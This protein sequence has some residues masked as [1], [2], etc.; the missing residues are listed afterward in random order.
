MARRLR[1]AISISLAAFLVLL[2]PGLE[3]PRIFAQVVGLA[4]AAGVRPIGVLPVA[5]PSALQIGAAPSLISAAP[6][7][8]VPSAFA[9]APS[10]AALTPAAHAAS[11]PD[12]AQAIAPHLEALAKPDATAS[13]AAAAGRGIEDVMTGAR[14]A[15][16]GDV[17]ISEGVEGAGALT[18]APAAAAP[19]ESDKP[20]VPAAAAPAEGKTV[21]SAQSYRAHRFLLKTIAALTGAAYSLP[22]AGP[23]LTQKLIASAAD[24]SAVFSDYD[25]TLAAYNQVLPEDMVSAVQAVKAAGK[26]FVVISDRG[27]EPRA[28][29]LTVFESLA[30][31][32][33][34]TR[35]GMYVAANSGGRVYRYDE[36]GEPVR[37]FEAPPLDEAAKAKVAEAAEATKAR[38]S[39][40]GAEQHVPSATNNNPSESWGTYGYAMMLKVGS[41]NEHVKGAAAILQEEL[42][43]RGLDVEVNPRFAKDPANPPYI[44]FSIVT[45]QTSAE[46]IA[47]AL[48]LEAKDVL[49][50]GDSMYTP[51]EA[52]KESFLTRLGAAL[53]GRALP[54]TGNR[55]DRNMEKAVPGA[56]TFSVGTTGDASAS[57]LWVLA[58][59]GPSVTR[60]VLMSVASKKKGEGGRS[61][62]S[63]VVAPVAVVAG[64]AAAYYFMIHGISNVVAGWEQTIQNDAHEFIKDGGAFFGGVLGL[65][66]LK[67]KIPASWKENAKKA[68][69][70][71]GAIA[72]IT[73]AAFGYH[74][75]LSAFGEVFKA[76]ADQ[77]NPSSVEPLAGLTLGALGAAGLGAMGG[78]QRLT[79]PRD[80][81]GDAYKKAVAIA[82]ER[83]IAEDQVQFS[84]AVAELPALH[85][86]RWNFWFSIPGKDGGRAAIFV[87][88][89]GAA[90]ALDLRTSVYE[91]MPE[92][93]TT[94]KAVAPFYFWIAL[95]GLDAEDAVAAA[96]RAQ[97]G[98]SERVLVALDHRV[99]PVSGD[100]DI[101]YR[102]SDQNGAVVSVNARTSETRVE[103]AVP[104]KD[105][106]RASISKKSP[107][108]GFST[109][110]YDAALAAAREHAVAIGYKPDNLR[111]TGAKLSPRE[112][113]EDWTF[114]FV[115]PRENILKDARAFELKVRRTMVAETQLDAYDL[116]DFGRSPLFVGF[117]AA[118]LPEF[119]KVSPMDIVAKTGDKAR[120]LELRGRWTG[121][122]GEPELWYVVRGEKGRELASYNANTGQLDETDRWAGWK[123]AAFTAGLMA[124][125]A[126]LYALLFWAFTHAPA[127]PNP[128][129]LPE[130]WQGGYPSGD[131][132]ALFGGTLGLAAGTLRGA[133][134]AKVADSEIEGAAKSVVAYKG[135]VWSSTEYNMGYYTTLESL[136]TRGATKAQLERFRK[137]CDEAPVIGGRF[138]P[139]SGD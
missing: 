35:S 44:N 53:S 39:E 97:P 102:V 111:V 104:G 57:N 130:G 7:L 51:T 119:V 19:S 34:E 72:L 41:S 76:G 124:A 117:S 136:K 32:P 113:G 107:V 28:H 122:D 131:I 15:G 49:V 126:G 95:R 82:A 59:K 56:L 40:F 20:A 21:S 67:A 125:T 22:V 77:F 83:G 52:K 108:D 10:A 11:V 4:P 98:M 92:Q 74:A 42:K 96:R 18:L 134:K 100:A 71:V 58:G 25:D 138:N 63:D 81:Y 33:V 29:Q 115:A 17:S 80:I 47:K 106:L 30:S 133:K 89:R 87:D 112:W 116:K 6:S 127:A 75:M 9:A 24:K 45:K 38:L 94:A 73:A 121:K 93:N 64:V 69:P 88:A 91:S 129:Q 139:W 99:E 50:I 26:D 5:A 101:W 1:A 62:L 78:G 132:G 85:G 31:I 90:D 103:A 3:A 135:G 120:T 48:K 110:V 65:G 8:T 36:K 68:A 12:M 61:I 2:S 123:S 66:G 55:T 86:S 14:S 16:T 43:K 54:K 37:V 23:A 118:K 60:Q 128:V 79:H 70:V 27:D 84:R 46:Y 13:G 137:L 109:F 114:S 105:S